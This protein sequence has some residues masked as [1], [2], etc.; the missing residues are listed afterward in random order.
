MIELEQILQCHEV[1]NLGTEFACENPLRHVELLYVYY[2]TS[3]MTDHLVIS[4]LNA[5]KVT[6]SQVTKKAP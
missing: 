6:Q 3:T 4:A 2:Y 1:Q 5:S